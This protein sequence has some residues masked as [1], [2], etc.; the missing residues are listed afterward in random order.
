MDSVLGQDISGRLRVVVIDDCSTDDTQKIL[1][2]YHARHG[3]TIAS[4]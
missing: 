3:D 1:R 4:Y 2:E